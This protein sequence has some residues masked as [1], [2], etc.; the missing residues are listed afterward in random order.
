MQLRSKNYYIILK[1]KF[2]LI[3]IYFIKNYFY[4]EIYLIIF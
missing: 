1:K 2:N 4:M 3:K